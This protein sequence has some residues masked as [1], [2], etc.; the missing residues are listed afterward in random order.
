MTYPGGT[1][2]EFELAKRGKRFPE[3]LAK[4]A[5]MIQI[6]IKYVHEF[7]SVACKGG[8]KGER[9]NRE[10]ME[11]IHPMRGDVLDKPS[12]KKPFVTFF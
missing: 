7:V 3:I 8:K 1:F 5:I 2:C 10:R 11:G 6:L 12:D 4:S 9:R